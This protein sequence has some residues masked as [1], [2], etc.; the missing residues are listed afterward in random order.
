M[1]DTGAGPSGV[2]ARALLV[3]PGLAGVAVQ[4]WERLSAS[5]A[6]PAAFLCAFALAAPSWLS[7]GARSALQA[8]DNEHL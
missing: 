4:A 3:L 8:L 1:C 6:F 2:L 7:A 5:A